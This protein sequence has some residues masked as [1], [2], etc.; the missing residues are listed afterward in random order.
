MTEITADNL[1]GKVMAP[2]AAYLTDKY[3]NR[4]LFGVVRGRCTEVSSSIYVL[5]ALSSIVTLLVPQLSVIIVQCKDCGEYWKATADYSIS[6]GETG[7]SGQLPLLSSW[8]CRSLRSMDVVHHR[9]S[10]PFM[11]YLLSQ[12][13]TMRTLQM[14][15]HPDNDITIINC[16]RC[17]CPPH[18][19]VVLV[20]QQHQEAGGG[21][22]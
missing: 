7:V 15:K 19:H 21:S 10:S 12:E 6:V 16:N 20:A 18:A 5:S 2:T 14:R 4:D 17:G 3:T 8:L 9:L 11:S 13:R 22:S 1:P